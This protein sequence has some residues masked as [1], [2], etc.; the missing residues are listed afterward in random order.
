MSTQA[1]SPQLVLNVFN[2]NCS[3]RDVVLLSSSLSTPLQVFSSDKCAAAG[4]AELVLLH[5][6]FLWKFLPNTQCRRRPNEPLLGL[7]TPITSDLFGCFRLTKKKKKSYEQ[8]NG[9]LMPPYSCTHC[10]GAAS[11]KTLRKLFSIFISKWPD[12]HLVNSHLTVG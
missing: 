10:V 9:T 2:L 6:F 7:M 5:C 11:T 12:Y 4:P 3:P 1:C 8:T